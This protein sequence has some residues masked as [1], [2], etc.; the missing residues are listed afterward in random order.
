MSNTMPSDKYNLNPVSKDALVTLNE[1]VKA[2]SYAV[3]AGTLEE[4]LERIAEA[5]RQLVNARY[6]AIG[7]PDGDGGLKYF[8]VAGL[9]K[10]AIE[11]IHHPPE[12]LGLLGEIMREREVIRLPD[13]TTHDSSVGFPEGHPAMTS[14]LG[15]PIEVGPQ[16]FGM[17]YLTDRLDGE[18]FND[19][20]QQLIET[21]AGYAALAIAGTQLSHQ[22]SRITL[23]EERERIAMD[24]HDGIIQELYAV[25]M[26]LELLRT[27]ASLGPD[28]LRPCIHSLNDVIDNIRGYIMDLRASNYRKQTMRSSMEDII[29]RLHVPDSITVEIDAPN[30][31]PSLAPVTFEAISQITNE[32]VSNALRH[33]EPSRI[34]VCTE[35]NLGWFIVTIMDDGKGFDLTD[36]TLR[37]GMGLRNI[38]ERARLHGG[39]VSIDS[40][41]G[42][43]TSLRVMVPTISTLPPSSP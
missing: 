43:G 23:L 26:Q 19:Y 37:M 8:K 21:I 40:T 17:L 38:R 31:Y 32:G 27:G 2:V 22:K 42:E 39:K 1:I 24:L 11:R 28:D 25:G 5:S 41:P 9:D 35:E 34:S 12:G 14:F 33:A 36:E 13:M 7:V 29:S 16:L 6:V 10:D 3:E 15:V 4:V 20:D 18:P 30:R